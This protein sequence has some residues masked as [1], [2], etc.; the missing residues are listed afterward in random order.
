MDAYARKLKETQLQGAAADT[1]LD[2]IELAKSVLKLEE[3]AEK[4]EDRLEELE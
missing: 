4:A 3:L 1:G 2:D